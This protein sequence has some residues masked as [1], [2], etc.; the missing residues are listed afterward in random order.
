MRTLRNRITV[1]GLALFMG[2]VGLVGE[3]TAQ[4]SPNVTDGGNRWLITYYNDC[5][6]A[7]SQWATQGICFLPYQSC[8]ACGIAGAWYSDTFPNWLGRYNQEGDRILMHG[9]WATFRGSDGMVIDLFGGTSPRDEGA[10]QWT[11]WWNTG[12]FGTTVGFGNTRLRRVGRCPLPR[13]HHI[14]QMGQED[15]NKLA[16]ELASK[17]KP[18]SRRDGKPAESPIDAEQVP[19][20]EEREFSK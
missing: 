14:S 10:G 12:Q 15:I 2:M 16:A 1:I 20:L 4:P 18:R 13:N 5:D 9:N 19:L 8:G 7:H 11:E 17:V 6:K 3:A